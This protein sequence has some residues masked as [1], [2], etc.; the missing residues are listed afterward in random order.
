M[1][2]HHK[3]EAVTDADSLAKLKATQ[4]A[5]K[6]KLNAASDDFSWVIPDFLGEE[7]E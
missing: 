1:R 3:P 7:W 6:A 4:A 5:R 2:D